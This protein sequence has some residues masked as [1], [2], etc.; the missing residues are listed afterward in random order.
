[1]NANTSSAALKDGPSASENG[2]R[3]KG[4]KLKKVV[5]AVHGI[6]K[7][8]RYATVQSVVGRFS[9]YGKCRAAVP[10]GNFHS[11]CKDGVAALRVPDSPPK[12]YPP[13]LLDTGFAEIFWAD[14]PEEAVNSRNT[15]EETKA[16]AKTVI[17]RVRAMDQQTHNRESVNYEKAAI[18]IDEMVDTIGVLE[19]LLVLAKKAGLGTFDLRKLL[20]DYIGDIQ[21]VT[22]FANYR[23]RILDHFHKV[24][25]E[26]NRRHEPEEIH[27]I[28][29][30]EG[31]VVAFLGLLQAMSRNGSEEFAWVDKVVG[32]MTI[33]SPIDKHLVLWPRLW[34]DLRPVKSAKRKRPID[35]RNYFDNGDPVGFE[36]DTARQWL[37]DGKWMS[38]PPAPDDLFHF[39]DDEEHDCGFTHYL[40]PGKAHNDYWKDKEVFEHFI[41][42]VVE[43]K[44]K[45]AHPAPSTSHL[46]CL[47]SWAVPYVLC[48]AILVVGTYILYKP[49]G[50]LVNPD[51]GF[52]VMLRNVFAIASLLAGM[53][54]MARVPR[55]T[56]C[57]WKYGLSVVVFGLGAVM[58]K[59]LID[60]PANEMMGLFFAQH[61]DWPA[62]RAIL[63]VLSGVAVAGGLISYAWPR[64]GLKGIVVLVG[65]VA[66]AVVWGILA[67]PG[68]LSKDPQKSVFWPVA[69]SG[70]LFLYLWW[71][72]ALL[73]DL[74]FVWHRYIRSNRAVEFLRTCDTR[75]KKEQEKEKF[76]PDVVGT[77]M[78]V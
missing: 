9:T 75:C 31:T 68:Q 46:A 29:H 25:R 8:F 32:F 3:P 56:K 64:S 10:L 77:G 78:P 61:L 17:E 41:S 69:L 40:F 16:W 21:I 59:W 55:M 39:P 28:A 34:D 53:T 18:V 72:S 73:F 13:G 5:V 67:G 60:P 49:V 27:I 45:D 33:G 15:L 30:S 58:Y 20:T 22:E 63:W 38:S 7:Q 42:N 1:M 76:A 74:V 12:D 6:G 44:E 65:L 70:A 24:L 14:I 54:V 37:I 4:P 36:L 26:L 62:E 35:W 19:N 51:Q 50:H 43:R 71:L 2:N 11:E 66:F 23:T 48:Y 52:S 47:F 57:L